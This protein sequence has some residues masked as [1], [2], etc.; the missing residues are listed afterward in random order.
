[1]GFV[2]ERVC[3]YGL[4]SQKGLPEFKAKKMLRATGM[5]LPAGSRNCVYGHNCKE[6]M[7]HWLVKCMVFKILRELGR[8]AGTETEVDGGIVDVIDADNFIAY[9]IESRPTRRK[10]E[11]AKRLGVKDVF[12][13]ELGKVPDDC[14]AAEIYLKSVMV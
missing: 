5:V 12:I 4:G 7:K 3:R 13:I 6:S 2:R 9:E 11:N 10:I 8:T 14:K 1:M